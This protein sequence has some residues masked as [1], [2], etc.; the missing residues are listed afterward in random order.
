TRSFD[1]VMLVKILGLYVHQVY[2]LGL[3]AKSNA[4]RAFADGS[5]LQETENYVKTS[6][7]L[8]DPNIFGTAKAKNVIVVSLESLQPL[9]IGATV[10]EQEV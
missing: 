1:C 10:N 7:S 2:D 9:L 5:K 6:Q 4:H 8:S 3:Q